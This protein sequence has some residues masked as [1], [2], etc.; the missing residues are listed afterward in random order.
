MSLKQYQIEDVNVF[1]RPFS[2]PFVEKGETHRNERET[3]FALFF[4]LFVHLCYLHKISLLNFVVF[5]LDSVSFEEYYK[6]TNETFFAYAE[7]SCHAST[8]KDGPRPD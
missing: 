4:C 7:R 2:A 3:F 1:L 5:I 8:K 6:D